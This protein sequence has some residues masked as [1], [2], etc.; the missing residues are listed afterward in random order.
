MKGI[1][2]PMKSLVGV[3]PNQQVDGR[4]RGS[5]SFLAMGLV[6]YTAFII[7]SMQYYHTSRNYIAIIHE[8]AILS[9]TC[10]QYNYFDH[11]S[12]TNVRRTASL[13]CSAVVGTWASHGAVHRHGCAAS[14]SSGCAAGMATAHA[15][16]I[17]TRSDCT[18]R[19]ICAG[20]Y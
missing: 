2:N 17:E 16:D 5:D 3:M 10:G 20:Q 14:A 11:Q 1:A 18:A 9:R 12:G 4:P 7:T 6:V 15:S 13:S 8:D 19:T